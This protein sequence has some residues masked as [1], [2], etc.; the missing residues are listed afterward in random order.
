MTRE[1][2]GEIL[3]GFEGRESPMDPSG[4]TNRGLSGGD[5]AGGGCPLAPRLRA[6]R[7]R[8]LK[9]RIGGSRSRYYEEKSGLI[10]SFSIN[11]KK[12]TDDARIFL[13]AESHSSRSISPL[14]KIS[15]NSPTPIV[16]L[17]GFGMIRTRSP[18][19]MYGC[20]PPEWGPSNPSILSFLISSL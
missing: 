18:L 3:A 5:R 19:T 4:L 11:P 1:G 10:A 16:A 13:Q 12:D 2:D 7:H 15:A 6:A 17:W 14:F 9:E 8:L 20:F